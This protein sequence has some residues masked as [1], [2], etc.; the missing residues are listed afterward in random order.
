VPAT[1]KDNGFNQLT[2]SASITKNTPVNKPKPGKEMIEQRA[3]ELKNGEHPPKAK[4]TLQSQATRNN[5]TRS[6]SVLSGRHRNIPSLK[7]KAMSPVKT[8]SSDY[9]DEDFD[10]LPSPSQLLGNKGHDAARTASPVVSSKAKGD[11]EAVPIVEKENVDVP[12]SSLSRPKPSGK[13]Q[14]NSRKD[15]TKPSTLRTQ[16]EII[17]I[18]DDTPQGSPG[19]PMPSDKDT[20]AKQSTMPPPAVIKQSPPLKRKASQD[21]TQKE[22]CSKRQKQVTP[23]PALQDHGSDALAEKE[24]LNSEQP[25]SPVAWTGMD[26]TAAW[27]DGIDLLDEFKDIIRLI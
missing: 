27:D 6:T 14:T 23:V 18:E 4:K 10:D 12:R 1:Q 11:T 19:P 13:D 24:P 8:V 21:E 5:E 3:K 9:G 2:I 20:P 22:K 17:V 15:Q 26:L 7:K 16:T 25:A